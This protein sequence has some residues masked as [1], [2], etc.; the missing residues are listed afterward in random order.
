MT[1]DY[2]PS[3]LTALVVDDNHYQRGITLDILRTIGT[4]RVL[5]APTAAEGWDLVVTQK[6]DLMFVDWMS[7]EFDGLELTR[8][9]RQSDESPH[10]GM[11]IF[12]LTAR[13][14]RADVEIAR[15]AG[16]NAFLRKPISVGVLEARL[17]AIVSRP[18]KFIETAT[19][20]G[21]CRRRRNDPTYAGP[22]RRLEDKIDAV[23]EHGEE[24]L[25]TALAKARIAVLEQIAQQLDPSDANSARR[26]FAAARELKTV[27]ENIAD[28]PLTL[29]SA[30]LVRY[31]ETQGAASGLDFEALR[32]HIN[33]L[34]QLGHL[35]NAM[36]DERMRVAQSL[37]KMVDKKL[38]K[39]NAA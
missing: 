28:G 14:A 37:T 21:P 39:S 26:V 22:R 30:E 29:A 5:Q 24:E 12:M 36:N 23:P 38:R 17:R 11:P 7:S 19:Y 3:R 25:N 20:V 8:R 32:T 33:A 34:H 35:P 2:D 15:R 13:G 6:P 4:G 18:Q 10:R 9:V 31:L 27:A 16:M 1:D